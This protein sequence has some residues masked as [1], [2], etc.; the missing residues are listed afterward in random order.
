MMS[1]LDLYTN[2]PK[3]I[4]DIK[5]HAEGPVGKLPL[6]ED[7]L[8]SLPS[9]NIFGM[10]I[11][12]GM[13]WTPETLANGDVLILGTGRYRKGWGTFRKVQYRVLFGTIDQRF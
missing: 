10:T 9:G 5:T 11:N 1:V 3:N 6:T 2:E 8:K 13:G 7:M 12:A 4:Y